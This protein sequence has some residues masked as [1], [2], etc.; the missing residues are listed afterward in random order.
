MLASR[1]SESAEPRRP[2]LPA[3]IAFLPV[4]FAIPFLAHQPK[5][6]SAA[7]YS[8]YVALLAL[9]AGSVFVKRGRRGM[10]IGAALACAAFTGLFVFY[11]NSAY[12]ASR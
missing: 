7:V 11:A 4:V 9:V 2:I 8:A 10:A 3:P 6:V 5:E 12:V 1:K